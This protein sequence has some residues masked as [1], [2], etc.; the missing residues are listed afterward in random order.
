[1]LAMTT[2]MPVRLPSPRVLPH[3]ATPRAAATTVSEE[4]A[5]GMRLVSLTSCTPR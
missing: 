3:R 2:A 4:A 1:M 5:T